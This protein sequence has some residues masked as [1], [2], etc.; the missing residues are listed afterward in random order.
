MHLHVE[1]TQFENGKQSTGP[2]TI[3]STSVLIA[4]LISTFFGSAVKVGRGF[5]LHL[6][7]QRSGRVSNSRKVIA[8]IAALLSRTSAQTGLAQPLHRTCD[9]LAH[10][11]I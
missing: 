3:I 4:S 6:S 8:E 9:Q 11:L 2:R 5:C 1:Q 7:W 10:G